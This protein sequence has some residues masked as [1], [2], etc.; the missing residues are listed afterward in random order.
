MTQRGRYVEAPEYYQQAAGDPPAVFLAG[1]LSGV[2]DWRAEVAA[3][4][5]VERCVVLNPRRARFDL[6]DPQAAA[7]QVAWEYH[8]LHHVPRLLTLFWFPISDPQIV[9]PIAL[10]ELGAQLELVQRSLDRHLVIGADPGYPRRQD[11]QL[12]V[13]HAA[14]ALVVHDTLDDVLHHTRALLNPDYAF[15]TGTW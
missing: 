5:L 11:V 9:Q 13:R 10:F 14:P 15:H 1:G 4:L 3:S 12:Q 8:H 6:D 2:A 7:E